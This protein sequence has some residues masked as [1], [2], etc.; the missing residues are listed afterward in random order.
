MVRV[1]WCR[2]SNAIS[3]PVKTVMWFLSSTLLISVDFCIN[4]SYVERWLIFVCWTILAFQ[5][6]ILL[7]RGVE[8]FNYT[9]EFIL[10]AFSWGLCQWCLSGIL[11]CHFSCDVFVWVWYQGNAGLL[12]W[13][14]N[15]LQFVPEFEECCWFFMFC[16]FTREDIR[17][18]S[19]LSTFTAWRL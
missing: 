3:A 16:E 18:R 15:I 9:A 13:V 14:R 10:L 7:L 6:E 5:E 19:C 12:G 8:S 4:I 17:S 2:F 1:D 11:A